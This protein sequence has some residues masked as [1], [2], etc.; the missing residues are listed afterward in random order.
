M[1]FGY[2]P[3]HR[4]PRTGSLILPAGAR[5][6][7]QF[8]YSAGMVVPAAGSVVGGPVVSRLW[9]MPSGVVNDNG[10]EWGFTPIYI[11][12]EEL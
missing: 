4:V 12:V 3:E 8:Q 1:D 11:L 2:N 6:D 7:G 9:Y 5:N 10:D